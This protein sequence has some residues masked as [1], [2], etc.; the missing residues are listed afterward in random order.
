MPNRTSTTLCCFSIPLYQAHTTH[1]SPSALPVGQ[2]GQGNN[3]H[4]FLYKSGEP[5]E[6][7]ASLKAISQANTKSSHRDCGD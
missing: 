5:V 2:T 1:F 4:Y 3:H 7:A 6:A